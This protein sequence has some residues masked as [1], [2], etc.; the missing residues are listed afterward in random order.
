MFRMIVKMEDGQKVTFKIY[1]TKGQERLR[2]ITRIHLKGT[3][4][5]ILMYSIDNKES[6]DDLENWL[7]I[8]KEEETFSRIS[9]IFHA[10]FRPQLLV[11]CGCSFSVKSWASTIC[12]AAGASRIHPCGCLISEALS[13]F[14]C[15]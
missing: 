12:S 3:D 8:L 11:F 6:F 4:S 10:Y 5:V 7:Q 15:G 9:S 2:K 14:R 13:S 1:D